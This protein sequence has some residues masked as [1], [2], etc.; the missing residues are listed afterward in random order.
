MIQVRLATKQDLEA[1]LKMDQELGEYL[2]DQIDLDLD[3]LDKVLIQEKSC[4]C[5]IAFDN[6]QPVGMAF[7]YY[8]FSTMLAKKG[9][10]LLDLYVR[11]KAR[12]KGVGKALF[13]Q[14]ACHALEHDCKRIDWDCLNW[15]S[16]SLE[17]YH[18]LNAQVRDDHTF[19]RLDED[20]IKQLTK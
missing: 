2:G 16:S 10:Y 5:Y 4:F 19:F 9:I 3:T 12:G 20:Q 18:H 6:N 8:T 13:N 15:N 17:V 11:E 7:C 14:L 1:V